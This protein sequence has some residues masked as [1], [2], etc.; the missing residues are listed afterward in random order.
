M[1]TT[2]GRGHQWDGQSSAK[3]SRETRP[4]GTK[5]PP[6]AGQSPQMRRHDQPS[7]FPAHL[8]GRSGLPPKADVGVHGVD[9]WPNLAKQVQTFGKFTVI[10]LDNVF[11][12]GCDGPAISTS[13]YCNQKKIRGMAE[14]DYHS[15]SLGCQNRTGYH[16]CAP[17]HRAFLQDI[18]Q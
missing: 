2:S 4:N 3:G 12:L 11:I 7:F 14:N 1:V 8:V 16:R 17:Q 6:N 15:H 9:L 5:P 13:K 10:L 18:F